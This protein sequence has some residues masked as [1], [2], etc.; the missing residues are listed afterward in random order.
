MLTRTTVSKS[1]QTCYK[2]ANRDGTGSAYKR[3]YKTEGGALHLCISHRK[4]RRINAELQESFSV[5]KAGVLIQANDDE[6]GYAC[7]PGTPLVGSRTGDRFVNGAF[8]EVVSP[9]GLIRDKLTDEI[10]ETTPEKMAKHTCLAWGVVYHRPQG[11]T[12]HDQ[13]V[14]LHD[15][16]SKFFSRPHLYAGLSRVTDGANIRIAE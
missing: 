7:V 8:Y 12:V 1:L 14:V 16:Q 5:G 3:S 13:K 4:R 11:L 2:V 9:H 15:L 10:I 6:A